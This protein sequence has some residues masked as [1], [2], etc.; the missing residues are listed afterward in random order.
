MLQT[1]RV[2][3]ESAPFIAFPSS[4][5]MLILTSHSFE[6]SFHN[7]FWGFR[8]PTL[9][10]LQCSTV[11]MPRRSCFQSFFLGSSRC[12]ICWMWGSSEKLSVSPGYAKG[13]AP[14]GNSFWPYPPLYWPWEHLILFLGFFPPPLL[15]GNT[16][17][18][19][20]GEY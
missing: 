13:T 1:Y 15:V 5:L 14:L 6:I 9:H 4:F 8:N 11:C 12:G 20:L 18:S 2:K 16:F 7:L 19:S 3:N 10:S 17:T